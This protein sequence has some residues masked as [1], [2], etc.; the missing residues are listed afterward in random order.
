MKSNLRFI[1]PVVLLALVPTP[2]DSTAFGN[3]DANACPI[4][5]DRKV[6]LLLKSIRQKYQVPAIAGAIVT[7][8]GVVT[9]GVAGVRKRGTTIP[10]TLADRWHLGSETKAMT[11]TLIATL[12]ERRQLKWDTTIAEVFPEL[13]SAF[14]PEMR[15]VTLRQ[16]LS[17]RAGLPA[18]PDLVRYRGKNAAKERLR[19]VRQV[20]TAPPR[21]KP[22]TKYEYSNLGYIIVG[23]IAEKVTGEDWERS[24]VDRVFTPLKMKHVGFGGMGT[25]GKVDQP[26]GHTANGDP[27]RANGPSVDN[28]PI[29][30]P[31]G[32]VHCTIQDWSKFVADQL[33]GARGE[34]SLLK[35]ATYKTLHTPPYGGSYALGWL[36]VSRKW[37][38]GN[39][40]HHS[41]S[42][43]MN[44]ATVWAAPKRGFAVLVCVNQGGDAANKACDVAASALIGHYQKFAND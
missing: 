11:A 37:G 2:D 28:P 33:R 16:L 22:G 6:A 23:A 36:V 15:K 43:T 24:M 4:A 21:T 8:K 26:W 42:N 12:V 35:R 27:V 34:R 20:L 44:Y 17:H 1:L 39:V 32:R 18:N 13:S 14:N 41:G 5:G 40:L 9:V 25:P 29:M 10:V 3:Q 19:A 31:A 38:G 7:S 30:G